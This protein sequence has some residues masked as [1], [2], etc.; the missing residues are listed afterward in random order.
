MSNIQLTN[1]LIYAEAADKDSQMSIEDVEVI[2]IDIPTKSGLI[3]SG[4]S[5][6]RGIIEKDIENQLPEYF[7]P[8]YISA[9]RKYF[10]NLRQVKGWKILH[11]DTPVL[12]FK[13]GHMVSGYDL[14]ITDDFK[15]KWMKYSQ[16]PMQKV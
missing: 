8:Y 16:S 15:N 9:E 2:D 13:S 4:I 3:F 7:Y 5:S 1:N 11:E 12:I 14:H 6:I 10:V